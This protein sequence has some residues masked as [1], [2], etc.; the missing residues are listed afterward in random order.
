MTARRFTLAPSGP[1]PS[2]AKA[3]ARRAYE[4]ATET[5][6]INACREIG[7]RKAG[8]MRAHARSAG[9]LLNG[10]AI[11]YRRSSDR[12]PGRIIVIAA[13]RWARWVG[14][15]VA[16]TAACLVLPGGAPAQDPAKLT[17][18]RAAYVPVATWLPAW[19]ALDKGIFA[20]HGLD[21]TLDAD[22]EPVAASRHG[23]PAI[24]VRRV[25][26]D[27][28]D[29]GGGRRARRGGKRGRGDRGSRATRPPR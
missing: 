21:V 12:R 24:R 23:R 18:I 3:L 6:R 15:V 25:D 26:A 9:A 13:Y 2:E 20:K 11:G 22:P 1:S 4:R 28:P 29:Q 7:E 5:A 16:A 10:G 17:P 14:V 27:R 19:V 8:V